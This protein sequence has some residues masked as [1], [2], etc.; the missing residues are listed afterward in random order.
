MY[1]H[2]F[3][4]SNDIPKSKVFYDATMA[5]LGYKAGVLDAKGRCMYFSKTGVLGLTTPLDGN[6]ASH[7]NGMTIGF[8][9]SSPEMV[10]RWHEAGLNSGGIE[11]E[12]PPG[13]RDTGDRKIYMAYLRDPTGNKVSATYFLD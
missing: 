7:G 1:S 8:L 12:D 2:I 11:C 6:V 4:G 10:D 13:I 9:A 5:T 3:L